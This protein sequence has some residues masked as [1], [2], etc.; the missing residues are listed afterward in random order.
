M[1][2]QIIENKFQVVEE[3]LS[4]MKVKSVSPMLIISTGEIAGRSQVIELYGESY[5]TVWSDLL[6]YYK[7][8]CLEQ[9]PYFRIDIVTEEKG[10]TFQQLQE[11]IGTVKRNNCGDFNFR[12]DGKKKYSFMMEELV[13]NAILKPSKEHKV[14]LN[15]PKLLIDEQN[16]RGYIKRKYGLKNAKVTELSENSLYLFKTKAFFFEN[17]QVFPLIDYGNGNRVREISDSNLDQMTDVVIKKGSDYLEHQLSE[18]GQFIYGYF[19]CYDQRIKG[20][21]SVRH[22]SSLYALAESIGY[23]ND[24]KMIP[25]LE[26]GIS[27][28]I[29]QLTSEM[30][31]YLLV[32]EPLSSNV[33]YK[34]GA[35]ATAILAIGKYSEITGDTQFY[36]ILKKLIISVKDKF[37][38]ND[39]HT[40]HVLDEKLKI[41]ERFRIVYYDGEILFALLRAYGIF[42]EAKI[43]QICEDLMN[44][45]I[46]DGYEKYHDHWLSY[47]T[48]EMLCYQ[49]KKEYYQ[50]G[51]TNVLG[52]INFID[53]RDTA[54]PTMLELLVAASKMIEKLSISELKI[55]FFQSSEEFDQVKN[56]INSVMRKR[57]QHELTTG[58]MF[59][60][61]A[62]FFK[63]PSTIGYGFFA[64]HDRFRM[65][66]D[67]AEHFLSG[68]INYRLHT[69]K[70]E[71]LW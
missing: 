71:E 59:P 7:K 3:L 51:L 67:D 48:N 31:G 26:Q 28:G 17:E 40:I 35:Q 22:F 13:G 66:I 6:S 65:R 10:I 20:Y 52:N 4:K 25:L 11:L 69:I 36:P 30:E 68:L 34:L 12:V 57:V 41:K 43:M 46:V 23:T 50:F 9:A 24:T 18:S 49:E 27:W 14:G 38:T 33:E 39:N 15:L 44:Q 2:I 58:V 19:P 70:E 45:F 29:N 56:R 55:E 42:K 62:Q 32:K 1:S 64:R 37:I 16:Y 61:F 5:Q 60:E 54:Y 8:N 53:K 47:A 63:Q 21:N